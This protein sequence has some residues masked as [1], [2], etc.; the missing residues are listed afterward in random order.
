MDENDLLTQTQERIEQIL[1]DFDALRV[2]LGDGKV[3]RQLL[4]EIFRHVHSLKASAQ[5]QELADL[6]KLAH[7][8]EDVL[9]AV[10][11]GRIGFDDHVLNVLNQTA[12]LF[13]DLLS[14]KESASAAALLNELGRICSTPAQRHKAK[15]E[16]IMSALPSDLRQSLTDEEKH[17]LQASVGEGANL[18]LI[19]TSFDVVDFDRQFQDLKDRVNRTGELISTAPQVEQDRSDKIDFRILYA[20]KADAETVRKDVAQFRLVSVSEITGLTQVAGA[21]S[22]PTPQVIDDREQPRYVRVNVEDLDRIIASAYA[23]TQRTEDIIGRASVTIEALDDVRQSALDLAASVVRIRLSSIERLLQRVERAGRAAAQSCGKEVEFQVLGEDVLLDQAM[24]DAIADPLIHLVRNAVDHGIEPRDVR[25]KE[26]KPASGR[27]SIEAMSLHGQTRIAIR[28]DGRGIDPNTIEAACARM[29]LTH[30]SFPLALEE[31][32]RMIFRSGFSTAESISEIS[33]RG[34]GLEV[35][36]TEIERLGGQIF[37]ASE[38][39][40]GS[41]FEVRLPVTFGLLD[42]VVVR[43]RDQRYVIDA[44]SVVAPTEVEPDEWPQFESMQLVELLGEPAYVDDRRTYALLLCEV[45]NDL[46]EPR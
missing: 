15:I 11:T 36:E 27:V 33:G 9:Q 6:S 34:V 30:H 23:L 37:V 3:E 20:R 32:V 21:E 18:F 26:G 22:V 16:S 1:S 41:I 42:A 35:V 28:D 24:S 25:L 12:Y 8:S 31:S 38:A 44:S 45:K 7:A 13:L 43:A 17:K 46:S 39:G 14:V 2:S 5:V 29:G 10:R 4:D 40:V 19:S